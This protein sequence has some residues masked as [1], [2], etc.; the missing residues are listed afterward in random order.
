M[1][2]LPN[3][4]WARLVAMNPDKEDIHLSEEPYEGQPNTEWKVYQKPTGDA[5]IINLSP[6]PIKINDDWLENNREKEIFS[7]QRIAFN[8]DKDSPDERF[9]YVFIS[10]NSQSRDSNK[11]NREDTSALPSNQEAAKLTKVM[12]GLEQELTCSICMRILHKCATLHPCQHTFCSFC[13]LSSFKSS[14]QC[15]LCRVEPTSITKNLVAQNL[16]ESTLK[17]FPEKERPREEIE[18]KQNEL[19]G[20]IIQAEKWTYIG[21]YQNGKREGKGNMIS[22]N[23]YFYE[24]VWKNDKREGK[25]VLTLPS[26]YRCKGEWRNDTVRNIEEMIIPDEGGYKGETECFRMNG[27]GALKFYNGDIY[28]GNFVKELQKGFGKYIFNDGEEYE[29]NWVK[30]EREGSG[31]MKFSNGDLYEGEWKNSKREGKGVLISANGDKYKGSWAQNDLQPLRK[32]YYANGDVY[33]GGIQ[34][35]N[36]QKHGEEVITYKNGNKF[37]GSWLNDKQHGK[38]REICKYVFEGVWE[39]GKMIGEIIM[40]DAN[41]KRYKAELKEL[42]EGERT[43]NQEMSDHFEATH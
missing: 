38:G 3:K 40:K 7:E 12:S 10:M 1:N 4:P 13:L 27:K 32:A 15:P 11:R 25:G 39:E 29:G 43:E 23:G 41:G 31:T 22:S 6:S 19:E 5:W 2:N 28:E 8:R 14:L 24:G 37:K 42:G 16:V 18:Q 35:E 36:L 34:V 30:G 33:K 21:V 20:E 17:S 9:D 26:G